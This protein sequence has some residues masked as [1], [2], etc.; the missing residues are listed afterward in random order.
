MTAQL[1]D[2]GVDR[3]MAVV[4]R[5]T[6][7]GKYQLTQSP[8][9]PLRT[10]YPSLTPAAADG[11]NR[12]THEQGPHLAASLE[13]ARADTEGFQILKS[14]GD[15]QGSWTYGTVRHLEARSNPVRQ[16][17]QQAHHVQE[18]ERTRKCHSSWFREDKDVG[19]GYP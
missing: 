16:V 2:L 18:P 17:S 8:P 4:R 14:R 10:R 15:Q 7:V 5:M 19:G 13:C 11:E 1:T 3:H 9:E 12:I 6:V